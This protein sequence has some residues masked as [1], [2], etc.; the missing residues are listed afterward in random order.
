MRRN[1][2]TTTRQRDPE[3][4]KIYA[5]RYYEKQKAKHKDGAGRPN[6]QSFFI[7]RSTALGSLIQAQ[8]RVV[9]VRDATMEEFYAWYI[10]LIDQTMTV[11][12]E[13]G[14]PV[15]A[16]RTLRRDAGQYRADMDDYAR[17]Y[18]IVEL[19]SLSVFHHSGLKMFVESTREIGELA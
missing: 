4:A 16:L 15:A 12:T 10:A 18:L 7:A 5:R 14:K 8:H 3:R 11:A 19:Y 1:K 9:E 6:I 2:T 17:Y 13:Q